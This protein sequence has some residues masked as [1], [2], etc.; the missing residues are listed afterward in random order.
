[1]SDIIHL[2]DRNAPPALPRGKLIFAID[3]TASREATWALAR[4]RQAD[5]FRKAAAVGRLEG[6]ACGLWRQ[7][8]SQIALEV[9]RRRDRPNDELDRL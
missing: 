7:L 4:E 6:E 1:M 3:A 8:V 2:S 5:M 9:E